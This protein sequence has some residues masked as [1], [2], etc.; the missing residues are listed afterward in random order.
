MSRGDFEQVGLSILTIFLFDLSNIDDQD[1][2]LDREAGFLP[3]PMQGWEVT[4]SCEE[5]ERRPHTHTHRAAR[6]DDCPALAAGRSQYVLKTHSQDG[7][8]GVEIPH[9]NS[10]TRS[11]TEKQSKTSQG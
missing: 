10:S 2:E 6:P 7:P 4:G 9:R 8:A 11:A 3:K 5:W 1:T